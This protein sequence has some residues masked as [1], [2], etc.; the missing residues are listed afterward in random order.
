LSHWLTASTIIIG[1]IDDS[2]SVDTQLSVIAGQAQTKV[3]AISF[4]SVSQASHTLQGI[5]Y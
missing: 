5:L 2:F 1:G 4:N 3:V